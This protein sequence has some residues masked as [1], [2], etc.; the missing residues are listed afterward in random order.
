MKKASEVMGKLQDDGV[1]YKYEAL[2]SGSTILVPE[3]EG[4]QLKAELVYE[5]YPKSGF[6]YDVFTN[7]VELTT[8]ESENSTIG[9]L[10]FRKEWALLYL[11][12]FQTLKMLK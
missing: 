7:N 5:G 12:F 2:S 11:H 4:E 3:S 9:A 8:S 10:S 6:T 1:D